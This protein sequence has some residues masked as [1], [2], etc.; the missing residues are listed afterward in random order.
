MFNRPEVIYGDFSYVLMD[1]DFALVTQLSTH[2]TAYI[3]LND[4]DWSLILDGYDPVYDSWEDGNGNI[5]YNL[6]F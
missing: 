3:S 5:L 1:Y 4:G 2:K 6:F